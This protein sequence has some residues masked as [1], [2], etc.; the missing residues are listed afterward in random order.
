MP[1]SGIAALGQH[2]FPGAMFEAIPE[3]DNPGC[4][5]GT[6]VQFLERVLAFLT[7]CTSPHIAWIAGMAGTGK[8][9]I[10]ITL[11][12]LQWANPS[13]LLGGSFFCSRSTG[14]VERTDVQRIVPTLTMTLARQFP[15]YASA[16]AKQLTDQPDVAHWTVRRQLEHLLTI[17]LLDIGGHDGQI[18]F[19][20]D[21][22]DECS[23]QGKLA[24][25]IHA[26]VDFV[27][28][29]PVKF[30]LTSRPEMYIR[31]TPISNPDLSFT[32]QVHTI[33]PTHVAEDMRLYICETLG[34]ESSG[35]TWYTYLDVE[36]LVQQSC[37]L[38]IFT[39]TA[40]KYILG[41]SNNEGR[42]ARLRKIV[43]AA[44]RSTALTANLDA[45]Y[46]LVLTEA[47]LPD[48]VDSDELA[49]TK[50]VL[51]CILTTRASL[52]ISAL[53]DILEI[54]P[55][56]L[57]GCL[58]RL[59]SL[60][61]VPE[62]DDDHSIRTLHASFGDYMFDRAEN[63]FSIKATLGHD[64]LA[65]GCLRRMAQD[66]LCFNVSRS[67]SS[68]KPNPDKIPDWIPMSLLYACLQWAHHIAAASNS[69]VFADKVNHTFRR[70]LLYWLEVLSITDNMSVASGLL[71]IAGSAVRLFCLFVHARNDSSCSRCGSRRLRS[72]FA[73]PI[74]SWHLLMQQ[75]YEARHTFTSRLSR[76]RLNILLS[77]SASGI[78][79][80]A[81]SLSQPLAL[82][83]MVKA[84][85]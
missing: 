21:A 4:M 83:I 11:C 57:R 7:G 30:L 47:S 20:I 76:S 85:L 22:L 40:L 48:N 58:E 1:N 42:M 84:S 34:R 13:V 25:L 28:V 19:V 49:D 81:Q 74:P 60:V 5:P 33:D 61:H 66:D 29:L 54:Q 41:R 3:S 17:P 36:A 8:T 12:K 71:L 53:A 67:Q 56:V 31:Q 38:F 70:K 51:A 2:H 78:A 9:S 18:V 15:T 50:R 73:T 52:S 14:T 37:G 69:L 64:T 79:T 72:F 80:P 24:E 43:E 77:T 44:S 68:F 82:P 27:S 23:D 55:A 75:S 6:R 62:D 26:L 63:Q 46:K 32:L 39:S 45:I 59:P 16:L 35:T 65:R 10:A